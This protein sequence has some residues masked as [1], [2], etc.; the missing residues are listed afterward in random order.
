[1]DNFLIDIDLFYIF[2]KTRRNYLYNLFG[3]EILIF[4]EKC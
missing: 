1:M 3:I 2:L 4:I